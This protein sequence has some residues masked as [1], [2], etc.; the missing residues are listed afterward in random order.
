MLA[1]RLCLAFGEQDPEQWL[2]KCPRRVLNIWRAFAQAEGWDTERYL[3]AQTAVAT[4]RLLLTKYQRDDR[5]KVMRSL[6]DEAA[7]YLSDYE[8]EERKADMPDP[9]VLKA[10]AKDSGE[11]LSVVASADAEIEGDVWQQL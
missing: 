8:K 1:C 5:E 7:S 10:L 9:G 11:L 4:R 2:E 3:A 6:F